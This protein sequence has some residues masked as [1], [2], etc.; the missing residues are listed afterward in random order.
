M[1][2]AF[3]SKHF[4]ISYSKGSAVFSAVVKSGSGEAFEPHSWIVV[5]VKQNVSAHGRIMLMSG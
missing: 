3:E 1:V 5:T 2:G 4:L